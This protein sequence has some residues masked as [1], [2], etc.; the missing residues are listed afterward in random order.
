MDIS[1]KCWEGLFFWW[2]ELLELAPSLPFIPIFTMDMIAGAAAA[3]W[4][5]QGNGIRT[6]VDNKEEE[7]EHIF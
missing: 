2:W 7:V 4:G 1:C 3:I 5:P 6:E